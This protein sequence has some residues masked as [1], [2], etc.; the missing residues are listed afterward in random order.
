M[1]P[2]GNHSECEALDGLRLITEATG[3]AGKTDLDATV[4]EKCEIIA[5]WCRARRAGGLPSA[6]GAGMAGTVVEL[7]AMEQITAGQDVIECPRILGLAE[8]ARPGGQ[9]LGT[10]VTSAVRNEVVYVRVTPRWPWQE[11]R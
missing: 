11:Q 9:P 8:V 5:A 4:M 10:A 1:M 6:A 7:R 2:E 3:L